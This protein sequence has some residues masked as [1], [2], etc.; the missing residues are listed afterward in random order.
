MKY[1]SRCTTVHRF[2]QVYSKRHAKSRASRNYN[3]LVL[4]SACCRLDA[5]GKLRTKAF[6]SLSLRKTFGLMRQM[7]TFM[8]FAHISQT[9]LDGALIRYLSNSA[10]CTQ[11]QRKASTTPSYEVPMHLFHALFFASHG[12]KGPTLV[13]KSDKSSI[14]NSSLPLHEDTYRP[15][16]YIQPRNDAKWRQRNTMINSSHGEEHYF[17]CAPA[18]LLIQ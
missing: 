1:N 18:N 10:R 4:R 14:P 5:N 16:T 7:C 8:C 13:A 9:A 3:V 17:I 11:R 2:R 15:L 12:Y 6:I